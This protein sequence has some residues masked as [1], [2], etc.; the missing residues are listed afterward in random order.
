MLA[1]E[2][3]CRFCAELIKQEAIKC[4]HCGSFVDGL[5][6]GGGAAGEMRTNPRDV[7]Y[8][9]VEALVFVALISI[10]FLAGGGLLLWFNNLPPAERARIERTAR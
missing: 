9:H 5:A 3:K 10:P 1:V 2:K 7:K 8:N 4:K 6:E